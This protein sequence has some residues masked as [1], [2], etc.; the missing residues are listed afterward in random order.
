MATFV[1]TIPTVQ[2]SEEFE[3]LANQVLETMGSSRA[4]T[5]FTNEVIH[6]ELPAPRA[7]ASSR[8]SNPNNSQPSGFVVI[9]EPRL[10][11]KSSSAIDS[12]F[13]TVPE[14]DP[15][16]KLLRFRTKTGSTS[17]HGDDSS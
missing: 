14:L 2:M 6:C 10:L 13:S 15:T 12:I 7:S 1:G 11:G 9:T 4:V 5:Y 3:F 8:A 16:D 17:H